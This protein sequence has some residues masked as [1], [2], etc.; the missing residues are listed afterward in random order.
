MPSSRPSR[1]TSRLL[2]LVGMTLATIL[3][4]A[5][6]RPSQ[7]A[8][9]EVP[10]EVAVG[11]LA[12]QGPGPLFRG[13]TLH[14]GVEVGLAAILDQAF[15]RRNIKRVPANMRAAAANMKEARIRP[16]IFIPSSFWLSP[17]LEGVGLIGVTWRPIGLALPLLDA[18][19]RIRLEAGA[20]LTYA[21]IW[22]DL[23]QLPTTH[24]LRPGIDLVLRTEV[25]V[26]DSVAVHLGL[27]GS[28]YVPQRP[29]RSFLYIGGAEDLDDSIWA[30]GRIFLQVAWRFPYRTRI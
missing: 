23:D 12:L 13:V 2:R 29:G 26:T 17:N 28:A 10:V 15:I 25:P 1:T 3:L 14:P 6:P 7:A 30:F 21:F 5:A 19:V 24:F 18:G 8:D 11:P 27:A 9:I 4:V 22:S 16:S 20:V